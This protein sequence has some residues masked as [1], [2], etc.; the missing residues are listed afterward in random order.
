MTDVAA[1]K[2]F[3]RQQVRRSK[4][5]A[6]YERE[7]C[8]AILDAARIAHVGFS[9][10]GQPFVIPMLFARDGDSVL[11]H[12]SV[13]SRLQTQLANGIETCISVTLLDGLVLARSQFHHSV[14]YRSAIAFGCARS[15]DDPAEKVAALIHI[16]DTL[17][18]GR[19]SESRAGDAQ[20]LAA[21][22][23]LRLELTD[24]SAKVRSGGPKDASA[25]LGLPVWSGVVPLQTL[26]GQAQPA[27]D[28]TAGMAVP[29]SVLRLIDSPTSTTT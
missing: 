5:R 14:N 12:G 8:Y 3:P 2:I 17:I 6:A 18:P 26:H 29:A 11:L 15:I 23:V 28:L 10:D 7:Q 1:R 21:T 16:V 4:E 22:T 24:I 25:D 13:A 19:A 20:E 27:A 9:V